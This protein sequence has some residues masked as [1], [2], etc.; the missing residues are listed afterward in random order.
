MTGYGNIAKNQA[1][2][3]VSKI[4]VQFDVRN[5]IINKLCTASR[6]TFQAWFY[7]TDPQNIGGQLETLSG[8][9]ETLFERERAKKKP[10]NIFRTEKIQDYF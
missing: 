8:L 7:K 5:K 9:L 10:R 6:M 4:C 1:R 3:L 2:R